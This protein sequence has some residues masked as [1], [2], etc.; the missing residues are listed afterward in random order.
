MQHRSKEPVGL[1]PDVLLREI[2]NPAVTGPFTS[3][4][5]DLLIEQS[6]EF[7]LPAIET[8]GGPRRPPRSPDDFGVVDVVVRQSQRVS[9]VRRGEN[10]PTEDELIA[11]HPRRD[12]EQRAENT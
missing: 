1:I 5:A 11:N 12:D 9:A 2:R 7:A 4:R 10:R 3:I 8:L 6:M